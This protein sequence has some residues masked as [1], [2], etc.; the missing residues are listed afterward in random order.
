MWTPRN[1]AFVDIASSHGV[2]DKF[3]SSTRALVAASNQVGRVSDNSPPLVVR[4]HGNV[5]FT[6]DH[7]PTTSEALLI[8][9]CF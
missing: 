3:D 7:A 5:I 8:E 4:R 6:W 2:A 1:H 9:A